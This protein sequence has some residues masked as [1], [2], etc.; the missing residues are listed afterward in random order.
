[1]RSA[2]LELLVPSVCPGCD[3]PR[4]ER[5]PLLCARCARGVA[6]LRELE[7]IPTAIAYRGTGARLVQRFKYDGRRDAL[8]ALLDP[9]TERL[10]PLRFHGIVPVPRHR[11]RI[12]ELGQDPVYDL[13]RALARRTGAPLWGSVLRRNRLTR[14][15][16]GLGPAARLANVAG[17]FSSRPGALR[18][19]VALLLDDVTTTGATLRTAA[20]ELRLGGLARAVLPAALAGTP[21]AAEP[22]LAG[23]PCAAL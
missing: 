14:T 13:A 9:L 3:E 18:G 5:E 11:K 19:R 10:R 21:A 20:A 1:M 4:R 8:D 23:A 12:R 6:T 22:S 15:Q 16:T 17:S 7:G 2:L